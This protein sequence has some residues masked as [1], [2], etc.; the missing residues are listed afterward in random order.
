MTRVLHLITELNTGGAQKALARL[1]AHLDRERFEPCVACLYNGDK[2][3]AQEIRKLG[4]PV[5]DLGMTG[6]ARWDAFWRLYRLLRRERPAILH[7]WMYHANVPGRLLGR[8]AGVPVIIT[9]R[10]NVDIGGTGRELINR[11]TSALDDRVIA[12]CEVVRQAEME[13][14]GVTAER[15][16]TIYNGVEVNRYT[17]LKAATRRRTRTALGAPL[18]APLLG[19][20]G[21]LHPQKNVAAL[22]AAM[23]QVKE[24]FPAARLVVVGDGEL[25]SALEAQAQ[26]LGLQSSV[27]FAGQRT[28]V[29]EILAA[30]DAFTLP[31]LWEGLPNAALEAM[32]A[33]LPVIA[34]RV[35]GVPEVVVDEVTGLLVPPGDSNALAEAIVRLLQDPDGRQAMGQAGR[36]RVRA[37]F[38]VERMVRETEALYEELT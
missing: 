18:E 27:I 35:G 19:F 34:T 31:S 25:R 30:L 3:V 38:S 28:D 7:T 22:L 33:G 17:E 15:V 36:E 1:L 13:R 8:L 10:R 32:A 23:K 21:R 12:V 24:R 14:A 26:A 11:W 4:I 6:K 5:T 37:H 9:S 2:A 16:V 20:V 29:P